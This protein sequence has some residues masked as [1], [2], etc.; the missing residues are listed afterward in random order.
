[1][2]TLPPH[3]DQYIHHTSAV[4]H[5][6]NEMFPMRVFGWLASLHHDRT[7]R[8]H[9]FMYVYT[10]FFFVL[11]YPENGEAQYFADDQTGVFEIVQAKDITHGKVM[12]QV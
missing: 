2:Y 3:S 5:T 4:L 11:V 1:M 8:N 12:K 6:Y 9:L 10:L 7:F